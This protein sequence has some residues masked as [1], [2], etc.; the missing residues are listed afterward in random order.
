MS[1]NVQAITEFLEMWYE[2]CV[3]FYTERH[4]KY[5]SALQAYHERNRE[6]CEWSNSCGYRTRR[7]NRDEYDQVVS[8]Y[9]KYR[10]AFHASWAY[11]TQFEHGP[12]CWEETM[13]KDLRE[14][15]NRKYDFII[16]RTNEIVGEILDASGLSVG[17]KGDLNGI[18][19]GTR[20]KASVT[21]FGAG[22]YNIQCFHFRTTIKE[23]K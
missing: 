20:G 16:Q 8:E 6:Y 2:R 15:Y 21:T 3:K 9:R 7:E 11:I 23:V 10:D 18:I 4:E 14:E 1:R 22:G 19:I 12:L 5:L 17:E 13:K